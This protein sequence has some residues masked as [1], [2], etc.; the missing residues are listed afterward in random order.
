MKLAAKIALA[1]LVSLAGLLLAGEW[2]ASTTKPGN[3]ALFVEDP[4]LFVV[5]RPGS[6]GFTFGDAR[7]IPVHINR[8]GLRGDELPEPRDPAE[9]RVLCIGDSFTFGGGVETEDA[10]PQQLQRLAGAPEASRIRVLNGGANGWDTAWQR[11]YLEKRGLAQL[12]PD[13]VILGFNWNDM[14]ISADPGADALKYFVRAEGSWLRVLARYAWIRNTHLYRLLYC[15]VHGSARIPSQEEL[16]SWYVEYKNKRIA[17]VID[18]EVRAQ[19]MRKNRFGDAEPDEA[20]WEATATGAWKQVRSEIA[21]MRALVE[22]RGARFLVAIM[23]EPSWDGPGTFPGVPRMARDLSALGIAWVDLQP[24]FIERTAEGRWQKKPG[25][26]Q[27][28]DPTHP[29]AAGHALYAARIAE[30]L[31]ELRLFEPK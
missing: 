19:Q 4:E 18:P 26:W 24:D 27:P 9:R 5:R 8:Y 10:W 28:Y 16:R 30:K 14:E 13:V 1:V 2:Y 29:T 21:K 17:Q 6:D 7:W 23:S 11:L 31:R 25:L 3:A 12:E 22:A 20:F 15:R